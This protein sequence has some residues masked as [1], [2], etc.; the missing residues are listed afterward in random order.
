MKKTLA[1]QI[2]K[3]AE[4]LRALVLKEY[5]RLDRIEKKSAQEKKDMVLNV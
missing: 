3:R 4:E 1:R 2:Y 5:W